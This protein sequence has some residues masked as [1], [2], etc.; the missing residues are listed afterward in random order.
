MSQQNEFK[1]NPDTINNETIEQ[2]KLSMTS[3]A[4]P[5]ID[6]DVL[7]YINELMEY[8]ELPHMIKLEQSDNKK[9]MNLVCG[10][11]NSKLSMN[12]INLLTSSDKYENLDKLLDLLDTMRDIKDGKKDIREEHSRFT[13]KMNEHFVYPKFGGK[14]NFEKEMSEPKK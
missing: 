6:N 10:R 1:I 12:M 8:T 9:F 5:N 7:P 4:I 11:F 2:Y 14:D 13:E 3:D